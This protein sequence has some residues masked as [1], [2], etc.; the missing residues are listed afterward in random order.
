[1]AD[2]SILEVLAQHSSRYF[3]ALPE[4]EIDAPESSGISVLDASQEEESVVV[5]S[6]QEIY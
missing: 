2:S 4:S 3:K 5:N 1:M 6:E